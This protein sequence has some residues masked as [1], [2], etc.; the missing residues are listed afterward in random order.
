MKI[1]I[2]TY[3]KSINNGAVLQCYSLSKRLQQEFP[4]HIVEVIDYHMPKIEEGYTP[5][6]R[7]YFRGPNVYIFFR[8]LL[9][10]IMTPG[11][12]SAEKKRFRAFMSVSGVLPLSADSIFEDE[13]GE[14]FRYINNNYDVVIAGSDAIWNYLSRG[15]PSPYYLD[16]S[17][18]CPKLSY[19]ASCYGMSYEKIPE[20]KKHRI[21]DILNDYCFL[22]V[23]DDES[24]LFL[25]HIGVTQEGIHTC[26]PTVFLDVND[27]PVSE[28]II[29]EKLRRKGFDFEKPAIG[30]M[31]TERM[32]RMVRRMY[33][34]QYQIVGLYNSYKCA[35]V[36]LYDLTPY[37]WAFV[38][39]YFKLT[40]TTFFHGTLLS[41]RNG[42]PVVCIALET[43][44]SKNHMTK[45][46]DLLARLELQ[47]CYF[48]TDY[49][50][51]NL[52]VIRKKADSLL[53]IQPKDEIL[54]KM[55]QEAECIRPFLQALEDVLA[56]QK[57]IEK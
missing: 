19:A 51:N 50:T 52:D 43:D 49:R 1:G 46:E 48:K 39:R 15:F 18:Y 44:Y 23:R 22:G 40:F 31:G 10:L 21:R 30:V 34:G 11:K 33:G 2:L 35:D 6:L 45:V 17:V 14:L 38:F 8:R 7:Q 13:T 9:S 16:T 36:Q 5:S 57:E 47:D 55:E 24:A 28:M 37:E 53:L 20:D 41:L 29:R 32:C 56:E 3:H 54:R 26:D 4:E 27:L 42:V 25:K 12:L